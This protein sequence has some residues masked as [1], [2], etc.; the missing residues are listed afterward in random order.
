[1]WETA[2]KLDYVGRDPVDA[3]MRRPCGR[4]PGLRAAVEANLLP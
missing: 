1:M 3:E 2:E 4:S